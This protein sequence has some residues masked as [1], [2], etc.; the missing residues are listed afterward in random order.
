MTET[1]CSG[2]FFSF[3]C[4]VVLGRVHSNTV[5]VLTGSDHTFDPAIKAQ[6]SSIDWRYQGN[7]VVEWE[8]GNDPIWYRHKER[9]NLDLNTGVLILKK[10]KK[11]DNG[12][13]K[14]LITVSGVIQNFEVT[15]NV[16][17]KCVS[18]WIFF[19]SV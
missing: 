1:F 5:A 13:Y 6:I 11:E 10:M 17:G 16:R 18:V 3:C 14:G 15:I 9:A 19:L 12:E 2:F 4:F 8:E 7:I